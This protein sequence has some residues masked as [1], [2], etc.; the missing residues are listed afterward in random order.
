MKATLAKPYTGNEN[1]IFIS[2]AHKDSALVLPLIRELQQRG[3]RIWYDEGILPGANWPEYIATHLSSAACVL[4]FVSNA[5]ATSTYCNM[6]ITMA[7]SKNKAMLPVYLEEFEIPASLQLQLGLFQS[8][9]YY[10]YI[11]TASLLDEMSVADI[12]RDCQDNSSLS[13]PQQEHL[14]VLT[15]QEKCSIAAV[16]GDAQAQYTLGECFLMGRGYDED[17]QKALYWFKESARQNYAPAQFALGL[18]Y[19][20]GHGVDADSHQAFTW[21]EKAAHNHFADAQFWLG[22]QLLSGKKE[23]YPQGLHWLN[24]AVRQGH[25]R[26]Q[27]TLGFCYEQGIGVAVDIPNAVNWY[28]LSAQQGTPEAQFRLGVIRYHGKDGVQDHDAAAE[29]FRQAAAQELPAAIYMLSE[30]MY[31]GLGIPAD[32][33]Q[34]AQL[35]VQA[36]QMDITEAKYQLAYELYTG[37]ERFQKN[38]EEAYAMFLK[39]AAADHPMANCAV[40]YCLSLG[41]GV[42]R[43]IFK[44]NDYFRKAEQLGVRKSTVKHLFS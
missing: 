33:E 2:Y 34:S 22:N 1:Y 9:F 20:H 3:F 13:A 39:L 5:S 4:A 15:D 40:G 18:C 41:H 44:A 25:A 29:Y 26:A 16:K 31:K 14:T 7:I 11:S 28:T 37:K 10:K 32:A 36:A 8:L 19:L 23:Y 21:I 42:K 43:N 30:C 12:L 17:P 27:L 6:E 38:P 35:L 24:Q